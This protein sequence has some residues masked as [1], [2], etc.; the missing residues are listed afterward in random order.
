MADSDKINLYKRIVHKQDELIDSFT[1]WVNLIKQ[2][3]LP[4][5]GKVVKLS[6][7]IRLEITELKKQLEKLNKRSGIILLN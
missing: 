3:K 1:D 4:E 7:K 6:N 5:A 2:D